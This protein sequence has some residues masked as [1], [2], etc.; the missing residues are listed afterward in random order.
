MVD[1]SVIQNYAIGGAMAA[2]FYVEPDT[3]LDLDIFCV[4]GVEAGSGLDLLVPLYDY[5][6]KR[7]YVPEAEIINIEG[8]PVQFLPV[9]NPL[10]EEAV[11]RC[12]VIR[13]GETPARV[14]TPEH[15]VAIMLQTGRPKDYARLIRFLASDLLNTERLNDIFS[16]HNLTGAWEEFKR[17]FV[18]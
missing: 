15:L 13:Y 12:N 6:R 3:T 7:G 1:D 16:R 9:F 18:K 14:M 4:P 2:L 8:L 5:L 17:R 10:N 11:E